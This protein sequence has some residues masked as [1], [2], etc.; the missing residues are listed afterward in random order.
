MPLRSS[1][2]SSERR[3][4]SLCA[5][6]LR[7][8]G[9][10]WALLFLLVFEAAV[11]RSDWFWTFPERSRSG[12]F[13]AVERR[14]MARRPNP[15]IVVVGSSRARDAVLPSALEH[16]L[17]LVTGDVANLAM[18]SGS[19]L[20]ARELLR[21]NPA[22][23]A[24]VDLIIVGVEDWYFLDG[25]PMQERE[26]LFADWS[27]QRDGWVQRGGW[28]RALREHGIK[29]LLGTRRMGAVIRAGPK[30]FRRMPLDNEDRLAWRIGD[31]STGPR[32]LDVSRDV[33]RYYDGATVARY[34]ITALRD[35]V[36]EGRRAGA[37]VVV[38]QIPLR[39]AYV[40]A[41]VRDHRDDWQQ[42]RAR[43]T[44]FCQ[45]LSVPLIAVDRAS[46]VNLVAT[47]FRDYG[48]MTASGARTYSTWL[49]SR[50][51]AV[52]RLPV[53]GRG[54]ETASPRDR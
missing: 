11:A 30:A 20:D 15:K 29:S 46:D 47:Q 32:E 28:P 10:L 49:G 51:R 2:S 26:R 3:E 19:P 7:P 13:Y 37:H 9:A 34:R 23:F 18:T 31:V 8:W 53:P 14:V 12:A 42:Y 22:Y 38:V 24:A 16:E 48:H 5:S 40:D 1:T 25:R 21:R 17:G 35:L 39:D 27:E 33:Q 4:P 50:V 52:A 45:G 54:E 36:T 41:V 6:G 43:L 44:A